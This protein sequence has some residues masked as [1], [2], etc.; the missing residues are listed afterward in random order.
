MF[1]PLAAAGDTKFTDQGLNP[2]SLTN[3]EYINRF[4]AVGLRFWV[5]VLAW[6]VDLVPS[7]SI[8]AAGAR[9][10]LKNDEL[11]RHPLKD[12]L[13]FRVQGSGFRV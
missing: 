12:S 4:R 10:A 6:V 11:L 1:L 7:F 8:H 2:K 3:N 13:G 5:V 9:R